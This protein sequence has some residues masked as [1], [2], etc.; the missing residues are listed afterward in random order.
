MTTERHLAVM[1]LMEAIEAPTK[2]YNAAVRKAWRTATDSD[3]N[4]AAI[5]KG[6]AALLEIEAAVRQWVTD[7][8]E[9]ESCGH[10]V[11]ENGPCARPAGHPGAYCR[12]ATGT[13][14]FLRRTPAVTA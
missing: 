12:D 14:R 8:P 6:N 1:R 10:T 5:T 4:K 11:G 13:Q 9:V 3:E 2:T 7:H